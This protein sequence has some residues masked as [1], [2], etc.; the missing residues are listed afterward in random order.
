M[1]P[2]AESFGYWSLTDYIC[3]LQ[4]SSHLFHGGLGLFAFHNIPKPPYH[5]LRFL[6]RL[7][8]QLIDRGDGWFAAKDT[9][10]GEIQIIFYNYCHYT[11]L[12]SSGENFDLSHTN[13][14]TIFSHPQKLQFSL[15]LT[16]LAAPAYRIREEFVNRQH[17]S[18]YDNWL[19]MGACEQL[20]P[21]EINVLRETSRPGMWIHREVPVCQRLDLEV[22]LEPFEVRLVTLHP[23][24][25]PW[26]AL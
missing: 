15:S 21:E 3:E 14:Y 13:R 24:D 20:T 5:T 7:W 17:G 10:R 2:S 16:D 1:R 19:S 8:D 11:H 12:F 4:P 9:D 23:L 26:E 22:I 25:S 18:A 6:F